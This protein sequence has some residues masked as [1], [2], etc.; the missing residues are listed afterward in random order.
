MR[1]PR[2]AEAE[3]GVCRPFLALV[4]VKFQIKDAKIKDDKH[5]LIIWTTTPWT[6]VA[7]VA[8]AVH[9]EMSYVSI[10]VGE[11]TFFLAQ[12]LSIGYWKIKY[13]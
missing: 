4:Y 7:N 10:K 12:D 8:V 5:F 11:E 13:S 6:L 1:E 9:P 3:S 2:F